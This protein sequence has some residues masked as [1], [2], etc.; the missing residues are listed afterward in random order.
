MF[1]AERVRRHLRLQRAAKEVPESLHAAVE[2]ERLLVL[3]RVVGEVRHGTL[4]V[5]RVGHRQ[6]AFQRPERRL[7]SGGLWQRHGSVSMCRYVRY[8]PLKERTN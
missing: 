2:Q 7:V 6:L 8:V 5:D 1:L 4:R 3:Q